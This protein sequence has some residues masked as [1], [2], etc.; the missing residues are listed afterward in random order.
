[1]VPQAIQVYQ[2]KMDFLAFLVTEVKLVCLAHLD[3]LAQ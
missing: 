3:N 1:M 2:A